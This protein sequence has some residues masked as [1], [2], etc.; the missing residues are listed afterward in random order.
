MPRSDALRAQDF[1]RRQ[2]KNRG[3]PTRSDLVDLIDRLTIHHNPPQGFEWI[4]E[5]CRA[6]GDGDT[7]DN[8]RLR[9]LAAK[10]APPSTN[11]RAKDG[12]KRA[13]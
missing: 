2:A 4:A 12:P 10:P 13:S 7:E 8:A 9:A 3:S 11:P 5:Y 6:I 1:R